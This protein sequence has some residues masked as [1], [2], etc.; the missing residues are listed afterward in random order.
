[1]PIWI[2][3]V[4]KWSSCRKIPFRFLFVNCDINFILE[5]RHRSLNVGIIRIHE[6]LGLW[7]NIGASKLP[8]I[9]VTVVGLFI[10]LWVERDLNLDLSTNLNRGTSW[11][12]NGERLWIDW[13]L[14]S[15]REHYNSRHNKGVFF[16]NCLG[17]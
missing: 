7:Y 9:D 1:M 13:F 2:T 10:S 4:Y 11:V 3:I 12:N 16:E 14:F 15:T 17:F 5:I 8:V 6:L